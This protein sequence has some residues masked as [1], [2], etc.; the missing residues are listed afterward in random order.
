[1]CNEIRK[2]PQKYPII[3]KIGEKAVQ[4]AYSYLAGETVKKYVT[5]PV[6]LI[7]VDNLK[8]YDMTGWQ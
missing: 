2:N 6:E 4:T 8:F 3:I 1:M 7:T 5:I